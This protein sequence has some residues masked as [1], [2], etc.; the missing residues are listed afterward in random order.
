VATSDVG[1]LWLNIQAE[2]NSVMGNSRQ[3]MATQATTTKRSNV[4]K[5]RPWK[6]VGRKGWPAAGEALHLRRPGHKPRK[7]MSTATISTNVS[8][9]PPWGKK[10]P[11]ECRAHR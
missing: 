10:N 8:T 2:K 3:E 6:N 9:C 11:R 1:T 5:L 7:R 4:A